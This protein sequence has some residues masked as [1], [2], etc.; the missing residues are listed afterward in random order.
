MA[1]EERQV[2]LY[3]DLGHVASDKPLIIPLSHL[4]LSQYSTGRA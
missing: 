2:R 4:L 1:K 3:G